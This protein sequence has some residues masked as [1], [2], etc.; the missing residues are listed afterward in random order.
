[1][2]E[3]ITAMNVNEDINML[4]IN[5]EKRERNQKQ[6]KR[7]SVSYSKLSTIQIN[8]NQNN[9]KQQP[10]SYEETSICLI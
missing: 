10:N 3:K 8:A 5:R 1:M 7:V 9:I 6:H 4:I 2:K